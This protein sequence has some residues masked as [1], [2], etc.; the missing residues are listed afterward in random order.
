MAS[1]K[2]L[3][4]QLSFYISIL[5]VNSGFSIEGFGN[6]NSE[7]LISTILHHLN[8][9]P[10]NVYNYNKGSLLNIHRKPDVIEAT[11]EVEVS[12]NNRFPGIP[13]NDAILI[14]HSYLSETGNSYMIL[15][16]VRC[17]P[18]IDV[19][20]EDFDNEKSAPLTDEDQSA[21]IDKLN[22]SHEALPPEQ[23]DP[24]FVAVRRET[25]PCLGCPFD[26]NKDV[27]GVDELVKIAIKHIESEKTNRYKITNIRRLQQQIVAGVKYILLADVAGTT[28]TKDADLSAP[29]TLDATVDPFICEVVFI[30][31]PWISKKKQIIKNNCTVSQEFMALNERNDINLIFRNPNKPRSYRPNYD[32]MAK[33]GSLDQQFDAGLLAYLESQILPESPSETSRKTQ[34][35]EQLSPRFTQR[36]TINGDEPPVINSQI[37]NLKLEPLNNVPEPQMRTLFVSMPIIEESE[38]V[39]MTYT[40]PNHNPGLFNAPDM[41]SSRE[42]F[43][44]HYIDDDDVFIRY[45][46]GSKNSAEEQEVKSNKSESDSNSSEGIK[47]KK[48]K[49]DNNS[50][51][52]SKEKIEMKKKNSS[53]EQS[54]SESSSE[55]KTEN[56]QQETTRVTET[57][58]VFVTEPVAEHKSE[59]ILESD[60]KS[61]NKS[62]NKTNWNSSDLRD[63]FEADNRRRNKRS[64]YLRNQQSDRKWK[65]SVGQLEKVPPE[66]KIIVRD[67]ADF[68]ANSLDNID[69]DN[70]KRVILQILGAKKLKLEGTYYQIILRLGISQCQEHEHHESCREKLF[71]NLTKI[72]KVQVHVDDDYSNPKVVKSQ[73]Q[74]IKKDENDR[75]RTNY[76]RYRRQILGGISPLS[77][78]DPNVKKFLS[79]V[80]LHLDFTSEHP[81]KHKIV[82]VVSASFQVVAGNKYVIETKIGL[83]KCKKTDNKLADTCD[84]LEEFDPDIC[85]VQ[86]LNQPWLNKTIYDIT[87]SEKKFSFENKPTS[88]T[89]SIC[90][91]CPINLPEDEA[92]IYLQRA[93]VHLDTT[94]SADHKYITVNILESSTQVVAGS[95]IKIKAEITTSNCSKSKVS[96]SNNCIKLEGSP[97]R[98]CTFS[99]WEKPWVNFTQTRVNCEGEAEQTFKSKRE[100]VEHRYTPLGRMFEHEN[101]GLYRDVANVVRKALQGLSIKTGSKRVFTIQYV[102]GVFSFRFNS[103]SEGDVVIA[104]ISNCGILDMPCESLMCAITIQDQFDILLG[105]KYTIK[106]ENDDQKYTFRETVKYE[107]EKEKKQAFGLFVKKFNKTYKSKDEYKYRLKVFKN[108]IDKIARLN[109]KEMGTAEY[110]ITEFADFTE[111]EFSKRHGYRPDLQNENE[112]SFTQASIPDITAIPTEFDWRTKGAVTEVKNQGACGSCWAFSVTGNVEGQYAIAHDKLLEFSEQELVDCDKIDQGCNGGLMDSAYRVIEQLGGLETESDYPYEGIDDKCNFNVN[113]IKVKLVSAVNISQNEKHMAKWL[114][115]KGPISIAINANAMQFYLGGV[116]HP[117]KVL[118]SPNNLDHGVLIVGYGVDTYKLFNKTLPFWIVKNSWG[119]FWGEQGYYRVYRGDGTCGLNQTPSSALV[120]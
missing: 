1:S 63:S 98:I 92:L 29:C 16:D 59:D 82:E 66:E 11:T 50:S 47:S 21:V 17:N 13:C 38:P 106:C 56:P 25:I 48:S 68:A 102:T 35:S 77:V 108:N 19:T 55:E 93:L 61:K 39:V 62:D 79:S 34:V 94:S 2:M 9:N 85:T 5:L 43:R 115:A 57:N 117:F 119:K 104:K 76:S 4:I 86:V 15:G 52:E 8:V 78:D 112:I 72:C 40:S 27:E 118:C 67:L 46:R 12:C 23:E 114:V 41:L 26:L 95:L 97:S 120:A 91:G 74:N 89:R 73:C 71:T 90:A 24:D 30:E 31:Q 116:S 105:T 45:V 87:C 53:L 113:K 96:E 99:I 33:T 3:R 64:A 42:T 20:V 111:E 109:E 110:G 49:S 37:H 44:N 10:N 60:E 36:E 84:L 6:V 80:L 70:H 75:N 101:G 107:S 100:A 18:K 65:R 88:R 58:N 54:R 28:C 7:S 81:N 103:D 22:L 32:A 83:T 51:E 69:D 14:C